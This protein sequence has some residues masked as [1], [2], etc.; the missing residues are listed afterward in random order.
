[1]ENVSQSAWKSGLRTAAFAVFGVAILL[2]IVSG[3]YVPFAKQR[4][5]AEARALVRGGDAVMRVYYLALDAGW[6]QDRLESLILGQAGDFYLAATEADPED[7]RAR[8][9]A[10][11]VLRALGRNREAASLIRGWRRDEFPESVRTAL[12]GLYAIVVSRNPSQ[13]AMEKAR[14]YAFEIGPGPLLLA[15]GYRDIGYEGRAREVLAEA[16]LQSRPFLRSLMAAAIVNALIFLSGIAW[17]VARVLRIR[18]R[19]SAEQS[20]GGPPTAPVGP[21]EAA[22]ALILWVFFSTLFAHTVSLLPVGEE[23]LALARLAPSALGA[24]VAIAWVWLVVRP[25]PGSAWR[26]RSSG[27]YAVSGLAA[28]GLSVIP[29]MLLYSIVQQVMGESPAQDPAVRLLAVPE[30]MLAKVVIVVAVGLI[31]PAVEETLFRGIVFGG[32]RSRWS[33]WA[34]AAA[35]AGL[36]AVAHLNVAGL[37]AYFLLGLLFAHLFERSRSL[38]SPWAAHA[39]FNIFNLAMLLTLFGS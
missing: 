3:S 38:V 31:A 16:A 30:G 1:M 13:E 10:M 19:I 6:E 7:L 17:V 18:R 23:G 27:G 39:A 33:F 22:E 21:R 26:L 25:G 34:A 24:L 32:F 8:L 11:S 14:D 12:G 36:F 37:A 29:V 20:P 35:S 28:A 5:P 4:S 9:S 2:G 15:T